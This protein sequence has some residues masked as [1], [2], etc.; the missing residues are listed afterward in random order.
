MNTILKWNFC[1]SKCMKYDPFI[2]FHTLNVMEIGYRTSYTS[3]STND[4]RLLVFTLE[5][6]ILLLST[7]PPIALFLLCLKMNFTFWPSIEETKKLGRPRTGTKTILDDLNGAGIGRPLRC[8]SGTA[9][10]NFFFP[11][12]E[13]WFFCL[14]HIFYNS[15]LLS[16]MG[17]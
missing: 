12:T 10:E 7:L 9:H 16:N 11:M 17:T 13:V 8:H 2:V 5:F 15:V 1:L 14:F 6:S 3:S 4:S